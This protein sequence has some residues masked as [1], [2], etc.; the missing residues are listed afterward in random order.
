[1][2]VEKSGMGD[3]EGAACNSPAVDM[4]TEARGYI[5]GLRA[6]KGYDYVDPDRVFI[7]GHSIGGLVGPVI[8][9]REP[10]KGL[11]VAETVGTSWYD[12][13]M[14]NIRRQ[15]VLKGV[16]Y[17]EVENDVRKYRNCKQLVWF[18]SKTPAD[19]I[20][21]NPDCVGMVED[22]APHTYM[23]Q[24]AGLN[25]ADTWKRVN[26]QVLVI[27]GA[28]DFVTS[29]EEHHY[30]RDML[31]KFRPGSATY[32]EIPEMDHWFERTASQQSSLARISAP[33]AGPPLFNES[34]L[35]ESLKWLETTSA[36]QRNP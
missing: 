24:I 26:A 7:F 3:S 35:T 11:I 33:P 34:I 32:V 23:R 17:D 30:L 2:R 10:V 4:E 5:A 15:R 27:Y 21:E 6:L 12:Y 28:S 13:S 18:D 1:M 9:S 36:K 29:A 8:A 25:L 20:K 19:V 16:P 14:E 31:N 22:A